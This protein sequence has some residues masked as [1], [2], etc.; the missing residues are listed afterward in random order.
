M[1]KLNELKDKVLGLHRVGINFKCC[2]ARI[3][4]ING[5]YSRGHYQAVIEDLWRHCCVRVVSHICIVVVSTAFDYYRVFK[6]SKKSEKVNVACRQEVVFTFS[7][8][9]GARVNMVCQNKF[10]A[11]LCTLC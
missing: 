2:D 9:F 11:C 1:I 5:C 4:T 8:I 7:V 3:L 10:D 6:F